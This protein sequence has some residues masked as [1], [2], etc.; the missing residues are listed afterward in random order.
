[1]NIGHFQ[2]FGLGFWQVPQATIGIEAVLVVAGAWLYYR[3]GRSVTKAA[4]APG[5]RRLQ[6]C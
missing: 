5:E 4:G 6:V 1:V 3:A 2:K